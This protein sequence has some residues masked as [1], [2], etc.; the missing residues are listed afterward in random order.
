MTDEKILSIFRKYPG[1]HVSGEE[2]SEELGISRA[3]IWKHI[4]DLRKIG[5]NIEAEPHLGYRLISL[6]DRLLSIELM[7]GLSTKI[8]GKSILSYDTV[9]STMDVAHDLAVK[10]KGEGVCVF[11]ESQKKGRGRMGRDWQSPKYKG[12]Y[13]S[14]ILRPDISP[15]ETPKITLMTAV[16][17]AKTIS[18]KFNLQP[19]IKW[20]ND[21]LIDNKKI[22]GILTEMNAEADK[23]KFLVVGIGIN[24]NSKQSDLVDTATSLKEKTGDKIDRIAFAKAVLEGLDE[25]Y[26]IFSKKGFQPTLD[27]LRNF[28]STLG[29]RVKVDF[30]NRHIEGQA[31]DVDDNGALLVR[32]DNGFTERILSGDVMLVR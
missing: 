20:P 10:T 21:L 28:S 8:I 2:L 6:P 24:V 29:R 7:H 26:A 19:Q 4:E 5:Y 12:I 18:S 32:T 13:V 31:M 16:S 11:A 1:Q 25:H 30:K 15:N 27:E 22:C 17:I 23:V 9:E 3:A 14:I